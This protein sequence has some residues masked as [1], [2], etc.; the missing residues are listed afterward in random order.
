MPTNGEGFSFYYNLDEKSI[1]KKWGK[2]K[3]TVRLS[4]GKPYSIL[5]VVSQE[6]FE[7]PTPGLEGL[8][9]IQLSY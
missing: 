8:C 7:P 3:N 6:G 9:S 1:G 5:F 2:M 4:L